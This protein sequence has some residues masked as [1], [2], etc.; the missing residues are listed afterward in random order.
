MRETL[1]DIRTLGF[2]ADGMQTIAADHPFDLLESGSGWQAS[3]Q[4]VGFLDIYGG[5]RVLRH[6]SSL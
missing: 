4:P 3:L 1:P 2:L 6:F 5:F